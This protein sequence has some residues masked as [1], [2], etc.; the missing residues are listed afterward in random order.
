M[1]GNLVTGRRGTALAM[2]V[3]LVISAAIG[4]LG[5]AR[6]SSGSDTGGKMATVRIMA[7]TGTSSADVGYWAEDHDPTG[8]LH[9]LLKTQRTD[10]GWVQVTS[11]PMILTAVPLW[12][13]GGASA[14]LVLTL[15]SA[16]IAA[17]A[18]RRLARQLG[19]SSG[20]AAFWLVG[21]G[22]PVLF[23]SADF[24]EHGPSVAIALWVVSLVLGMADGDGG[25]RGLITAIVTG[26][27]AAL[28]VTLRSE[29]AL[30]FGFIALTLVATKVERSRLTSRLPHF[31]LAAASFAFMSTVWLRFESPKLGTVSR[32]PRTSS[33]LGQA[34]LDVGQRMKDA[35][36]TSIGLW[37]SQ[38]LVSFLLGA[39]VVGL[40][41]FG[42]RMA[43]NGRAL[44]GA[45]LAL[46]VLLVLLRAVDLGFI[47]GA[48]LAAPAAIASIGVSTVRQKALAIGVVLATA[49]TWALSW[50]GD[51]QSQWGGR[52]L[53]VPAAVLVVLGAVTLER[54]G[55]R[56]PISIAIVGLTAFVGV[57]GATWH[58]VRSRSVGVAID[59]VEDVPG[60]VILVSTGIDNG[61]TA[62]AWYGEHRWFT[63]IGTVEL[64]RI[65]AIAG[66]I[67][68][69]RIDVVYPE[70]IDGERPIDGATETGRRSIAVLDGVEFT[71]VSYQPVSG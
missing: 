7:E 26:A 60:D 59:Q 68:A 36:L 13:I 61:R 67:Q 5:D 49:A 35:A 46:A 39:I 34:G 62:G 55:W 71:V 32:G 19:A 40:L 27:L 56:A 25:R 11:L 20:Q 44:P 31:A 28:C 66:D 12:S 15:P 6:I 29:V 17:L 57:Y 54:I 4:I 37:P 18:A 45:A 41:A 38:D 33:Q 65:M 3:I 51:M 69:P 23:Y 9:Q 1:F 30:S 14:L 64:E 48:L 42:V 63:A 43:V 70:P 24:W 47:P 16:A 10:E 58:I 52:Y 8:E 50:S 2:L 22:S 53:L 21:L